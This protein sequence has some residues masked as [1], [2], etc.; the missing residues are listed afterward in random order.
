[1]KMINYF[2]SVTYKFFEIKFTQLIFPFEL[3]IRILIYP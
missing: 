2:F 3:F 1:M